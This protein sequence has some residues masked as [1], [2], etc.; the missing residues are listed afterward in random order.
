MQEQHVCSSAAKI[1]HLEIELNRLRN[2]STTDHDLI[3]EIKTQVGMILAAV[4]EP[5][6]RYENLK[7]AIYGGV[8]VGVILYLLS[9]LF[10]KL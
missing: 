10:E 3:L 9:Y 6:K 5:R 8:G 4:N 7:F 1:E 2:T